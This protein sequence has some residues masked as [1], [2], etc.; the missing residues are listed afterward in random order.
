MKISK[1]SIANSYIYAD[2]FRLKNHKTKIFL[3]MFHGFCETFIIINYQFDLQ[4]DLSGERIRFFLPETAYKSA[5]KL[6]KI[7]LSRYRVAGIWHKISKITLSCF[8]AS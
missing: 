1:F 8:T 2:K 6:R 3:P 7:R 4:S 5:E